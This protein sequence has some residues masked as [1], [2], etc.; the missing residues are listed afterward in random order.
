MKTLLLTAL[1]WVSKVPGSTINEIFAT[2]SDVI[3][4][5]EKANTA[6]GWEKLRTS[7]E[8]I[9]SV[10]PL[11]A[12]YKSI[13]SVVVTIVVNVALLVIRMKAPGK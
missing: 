6:S 13:A 9:L 7:V 8:Y 1:G 2:A 3:A 10:I 4:S 5:T 11:D 12:R